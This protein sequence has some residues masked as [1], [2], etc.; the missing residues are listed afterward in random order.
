MEKS[1]SFSN[2]REFFDS[3]FPGLVNDIVKEGE[4]DRETGDASQHM[5]KVLEYNVPGGKR[6]RGL[7][8][9]GSLRH[10]VSPD[11]LTEEQLK[12]AS[13]LGWCVEWLQAFFLVAD[14][15]MDESLTRRGKPCWY[16]KAEV[17]NIA[18]NDFLLIE[19]TIY[20]L[21]WMHVREQPYYIDVLHLFHEVTYQTATGQTLDLITQPGENFENFTLERYKAIVK[22]KTAFYSFYLPVALAMY[23]AGIKDA[24]SHDNAKVILLAMGEFFQIQDDYLDC[25]GDPAVTGKVGT[26]IEERKCSWL[27]VQALNRISDKQMQILKDN[28]GV[29]NSA[30]SDKVKKLYNELELK[31]LYQEYEE[32]SYQQILQLIA[33]KSENL[34]KEMFLEFVKKI[35]KRDK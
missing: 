17:S 2:D 8:V 5:R 21:L 33:R 7:S 11:K 27:V 4:N 20:K 31:K 1:T 15:I 32:E 19:A 25:Y 24:S 30:A 29:K 18:V 14:D 16:L 10:L 3:F 6:N 22:F 34:P 9:I 12:T 28:Y 13:I 23:M 35:Y 26:D